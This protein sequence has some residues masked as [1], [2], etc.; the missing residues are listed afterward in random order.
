MANLMLHDLSGL[1]PI[2]VRYSG[3]GGETLVDLCRA[4][5]AMFWTPQAAW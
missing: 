2:V 5:D 3:L 4:P 1:L